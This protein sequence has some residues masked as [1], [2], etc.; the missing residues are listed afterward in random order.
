MKIRLPMQ[1]KM[2]IQALFALRWSGRLLLGKLF[3]GLFMIPVIVAFPL[4][5][6]V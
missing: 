4:S 6:N 3:F 1:K 2:C 5:R